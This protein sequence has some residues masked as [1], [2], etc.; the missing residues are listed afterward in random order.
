M[1][2]RVTDSMLTNNYLVN[3]RR[4]LNNMKT[5]QD[6]L[7]SYKKIQRA[8]DNPYIASRSMQL[9]MEISYNK[10]YNENIKDVTNWLDT[11]DTSLAQ[12][13]N[14]FGRIETLLVNA[15][16]GTF[17]DLERGSIQDEIKEKVNSLSQLLNTNFDGSYIFGGTKTDTKPTTVVNGKLEYA[18]KDGNAVEINEYLDITTNTITTNPG[19]ANAPYA[20]A[21]TDAE[22]DALKSE[23]ALPT[24]SDYRRADITKLLQGAPIYKTG[25]GAYTAEPNANI[26]ITLSATDITK[27]QTE[28][29]NSSTSAA[30]IDEINS[31]LYNTNTAAGGLTLGQISAFQ[32]AV[33]NSTAT[34]AQIAQLNAASK[35]TAID[36]TNSDLKVDISE[37]VTNAYNTTAIDVMEFT[38]KNGKYINV[39]DLLNNIIADLG[40]DGNRNNLITTDLDEIQATTANLLN[41][42]AKVGSVQNRMDSAQSN[43]EDQSYNLTDILSKTEDVDVAETTMNYSIMQTVYTASLQTSAK[44]LP[45][46]ILNYLS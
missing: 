21:L 6:Q 30:R 38:D 31:M 14:V 15:G 12:I 22:K 34:P 8:S 35:V 10:Q 37:G 45:M 9:N 24:T 25:A 43:N 27:L 39:S 29:N 33:K 5:L 18:D 28:L 13:G 7:A 40:P 19:A 11:T 44:I 17:S 26:A 16:N 23:A 42:R 2:S 20:T 4:N 3:S 1:A 41:Q 36:Q 46:T 32:T